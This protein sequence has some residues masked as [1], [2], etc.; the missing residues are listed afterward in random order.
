MVQTVYFVKKGDK[1]VPTSNFEDVVS[2]EIN[3]YSLYNPDKF[4]KVHQDT[5]LGEN[6]SDIDYVITVPYIKE[7]P[8]TDLPDP[9]ESRQSTWTIHYVGLDK[10]PDDVV[11]TSQ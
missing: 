5:K 3:G 10:N 9:M 7:V 2:P 8:G 1:F 4:A 11:Q 6:D